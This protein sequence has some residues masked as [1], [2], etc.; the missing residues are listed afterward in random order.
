MAKK[1]RVVINQELC[2]GCYLCIKAC[3]VQVL[4]ADTQPN[5]SGSYPSR[6]LNIEKCIACGNCYTL[7]PDVCI[8]VYE[9]EE[10]ETRGGAA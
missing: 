8:D 5:S 9:L 3:P 2:K 1:G 6:A 10:G 4:G 7:C